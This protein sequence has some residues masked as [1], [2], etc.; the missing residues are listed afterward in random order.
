MLAFFSGKSP[1][2]TTL[3]DHLHGNVEIRNFSSSVENISRLAKWSSGVKYFQK[4][5]NNFVPLSHQVMFYL[6]YKSQ[7]IHFNIFLG[8]IRCDLSCC[9]SNNDLFT[10]EKNNV[11]ICLHFWLL[12]SKKLPKRRQVM[13]WTMVEFLVICVS[14]SFKNE[15]AF[16]K[17]EK[18]RNKHRRT[19]MRWSE[20][21]QC[22]TVTLKI[23]KI[24]VN[25]ALCS[26]THSLP[27]ILPKNAFWSYLSAFLVTVVL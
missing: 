22:S 24:I 9:H 26:L 19:V 12:Y 23:W 8:C 15:N 4:S 6:L 25:L 7:W 17:I 11:L 27:E 21:L 13:N 16:M 20:T 14:F 2:N 1:D 3:N 10:C 18:W 5:K